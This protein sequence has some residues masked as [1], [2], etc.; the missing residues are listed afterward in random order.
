LFQ[1]LFS[2]TEP[3]VGLI[4]GAVL[5]AQ[6]AA[7]GALP[8]GL[9][10]DLVVD[11]V[12]GGVG[13]VL[14]FVPQIVF[15]FVLIGLLED[16]GYMARVAYLMD[17]VMRGLGLHGRAFVPML[18]GFACAIPAI[19]ATRTMERRRDRLLTMLVIPLMTCS[20]RLPVYA[21]VIGA[22]MPER[23][24]DGRAPLH[25]PLL[26]AMYVLASLVA[27]AAAA[28]LGRTVV[29]GRRVPLILEL[30]PYRRPELAS[31]LRGT[32]ERTASFL[33]DAG[34]T[35]LGATIVLWALLSFPRFEA[36]A[37][38]PEAERSQAA[39]EQS[40][41]GR[42]GHAIEPLIEPLGFDWKIGVGLV[43]AFAAREVFVST[44]GL[45]EGLGSVDDEAIPLRERLRAEVKADGTPRYTAPVGAALL[46][47]F[48]VACQCV[49]TLAVVRRE[50]GTFGWPAFLFAYTL[51]LAWV[52]AFAVH[53]AGL[54][55]AAL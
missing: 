4:E 22:T 1:G 17:R 42:L 37:E 32:W 52:L 31:T 10:R 14:V 44:L 16:S 27:L 11:G 39:L 6:Q 47:F 25:G 20:A 49:S 2:G 53:G 51:A 28:V 13:N 30:P 40:Y 38:L 26:A 18:S 34:T 3:L 9:L 46:V 24:L 15:L 36:P 19:L 21:L 5:A 55:L 43:G 23:F 45:V 54:W 12:L 8:G 29:R 35:I 48:A 7:A 33:R 50:T 41:G